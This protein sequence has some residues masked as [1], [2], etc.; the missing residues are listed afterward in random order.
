MVACDRRWVLMHELRDEAEPTLAEHIARFSPCD[1]VLVE[2]FKR[3]AIPKLEVHRPSFGRPLLAPE[4]PNI[5]AIASDGPVASRLPIL[6][7]NHPAGIAEFIISH[8]NLA[9]R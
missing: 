8:L 5:V 1:L 2:G 6:D 9:S 7:I 3:A 4:D